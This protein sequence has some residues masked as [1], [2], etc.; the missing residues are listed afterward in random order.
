MDTLVV[1]KEPLVKDLLTKDLPTKEPLAKFRYQPRP[2]RG[3]RCRQRIPPLEGA[4]STRQ[5]VTAAKAVN[6]A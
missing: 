6:E 1:N 2:R 4:G 5:L 3:R